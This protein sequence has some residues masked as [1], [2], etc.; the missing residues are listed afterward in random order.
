MILALGIPKGGGRVLA[1]CLIVSNHESML[2]GKN[3]NVT[4]STVRLMGVMML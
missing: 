4:N 3:T 2:I 1:L